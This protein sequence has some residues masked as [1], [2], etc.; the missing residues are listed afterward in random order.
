MRCEELLKGLSY[1][2]IRGN[3]ECEI[4]EVVY[5]SRKLSEGCL[6]ICIS[7]YKVDG[8]RPAAVRQRSWWKRMCCC[9]KEAARR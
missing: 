8:K 9:R 6:F 7:G 1:E 5:D 4:K 3:T 2:C